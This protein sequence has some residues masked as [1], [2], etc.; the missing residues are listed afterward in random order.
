ML[1]L[2][3]EPFADGLERLLTAYQAVKWQA[4]DDAMQAEREKPG[5]IDNADFI[6]SLERVTGSDP[7]MTQGLAGGRQAT[8]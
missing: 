4:L 1:G 7:M 5:V 3:Y 8:G 2:S 6:K